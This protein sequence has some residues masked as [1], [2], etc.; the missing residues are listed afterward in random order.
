MIGFFEYQYLSY[1]K[2]HLRN[3]LALARADG[4]FHQ[5]EE[6]LLYKL[7]EK[8]R[9]KERQVKS[10]IASTKPQELHIPNGHEEKMELLYDVLLMVYADGVVDKNE[11]EFCHHL[12]ER[13]GY[14]EEMVEWLLEEFKT[15]RPPHPIEWD[16]MVADAKERFMQK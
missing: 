14:K 4:T 2:N 12:V 10:L 1:K 16:G 8:Y 15:G 6:R 9:L 3:L 11:I 13:F 7:G 5:N